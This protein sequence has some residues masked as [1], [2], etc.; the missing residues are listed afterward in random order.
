MTNEI[1]MSIAPVVF[2]A[3]LLRTRWLRRLPRSA[4]A[5]IGSTEAESTDIHDH[6]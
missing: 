2:A 6:A 5:R 3:G 1:L 4:Y